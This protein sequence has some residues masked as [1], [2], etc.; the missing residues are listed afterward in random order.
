MSFS[1][2]VLDFTQ[3]LTTNQ[4]WC[5]GQ[6]QENNSSGKFLTLKIRCQYNNDSKPCVRTKHTHWNR[7]PF[8]CLTNQVKEVN[9]QTALIP[10]HISP[11]Y[12]SKIFV[13]SALFSMKTKNRRK[14]SD[15]KIFQI[16]QLF[17]MIQLHV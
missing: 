6:C 8:I 3:H 12:P 2:D 15:K 17:F 16:I 11:S 4:F 10:A 7:A 1:S 9:N 13:S 14:T 5:P